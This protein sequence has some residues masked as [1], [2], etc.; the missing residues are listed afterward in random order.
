MNVENEKT[1]YIPFKFE[2]YQQITWWEKYPKVIFLIPIILWTILLCILLQQ[3]KV[4]ASSK[5]YDFKLEDVILMT[6]LVDGDFRKTGDGEFNINHQNPNYNEIY[7]VLC[8]VMNRQRNKHFP[9]SIKEI[10]LQPGQFEVMPRNSDAIPHWKSFWIVLQWC[11][12]Y[13]IYDKSIQ[14]IPKD[15]LYFYGDGL[16]N[17]TRKC[18]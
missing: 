1:K 12:N 4:E 16:K 17:H 2:R 13:D 9:N 14:V 8:V 6:Q 11:N 18:F 5:S 10:I 3:F 7:K 15:H